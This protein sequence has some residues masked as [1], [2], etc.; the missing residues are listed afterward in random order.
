MEVGDRV[1]LL[2]YDLHGAWPRGV[3]AVPGATTFVGSKAEVV[4]IFAS[5][6]SVRLPLEAGRSLILRWPMSAL[7]PWLEVGDR[8]RLLDYDLPDGWMPQH[9]AHKYIGSEGEVSSTNRFWVKVT[10]VTGVRNLVLL[11]WPIDCVEK[12]S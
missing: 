12:L 10:V 6:A 1:R 5:F 9:R 7:R 3:L 11:N 2:E 8:V 4:E